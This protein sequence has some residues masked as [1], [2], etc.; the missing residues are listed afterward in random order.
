MASIKDVKA[1]AQQFLSKGNYQKALKYYQAI[2]D[3]LEE[4]NTPDITLYNKVGDI[5]LSKMDN[6]DIA[7]ENFRKAMYL[8]GKDSLYPN[9]IA[10]AKKILKTDSNQIEMYRKIG[11][12]NREQGLVGE[13][14]NNFIN[15][16]EK[17]LQN[18]DRKAAIEAFKDTLDMMPE[19]IEIKEKLVDLYVQEEELEKAIELLK[20]VEG[21]YV[22]RNDMEQA[23]LIRQKITKYSKQAGIVT[24]PVE[25]EKPQPKPAQAA[26]SSEEEIDIEDFDMSDLVD[27]LTQ[28]LDESFSEESEKTSAPPASAPEPEGAEALEEETESTGS[29]ESEIYLQ[30]VQMGELSENY[31]ANEAANFYYQAAEGYTSIE[32]Y[33]NAIGAYRKIVNLKENEMKAHKAIIDLSIKTSQPSKAVDSYLY[34]AK[35]S[36]DKEPE[37]TMKLIDTVLAADPANQEAI[38]MKSRLTQAQ[39]PPQQPEPAKHEQKPAQAEPMETDFLSEFKEE[40]TEDLSGDDLMKESEDMTARDIVNGKNEGKRPKFSIEQ[41]SQQQSDEVWSL[42]ELLDELKEGVNE[43]LSDED[44]SSHYDLG[45]S[46]KEMGLHD[47]A[48]EELK[49]SLANPEY[50]LKSLEMLGQC[51]FEKNDLETAEHTL[52]EAMSI[53]GKKPEEYLGIKYTLARIYE[54]RQMLEQALKM[55]TQIKQTDASFKNIDKHIALIKEAM[56]KKIQKEQV[57]KEKTGAAAETPDDGMVDF[58]ALLKDEDIAQEEESEFD[59]I[60]IDL[61]DDDDNNKSKNISYM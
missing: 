11:E 52:I 5:Y 2:I 24:K 4:K 3:K 48:I 1:K 30:Y 19:R 12:F 29:E 37:K 60:E 17:S 61:D 20:E 13:A 16:A 15:F 34:L 38:A 54:S 50:K 32:E 18:G 40:I 28:E 44:V 35:Q 21:H 6:K 31:D 7:I 14:L 43:N 59:D 47:M 26:P 51:Y 9:A 41:D 10:M 25:K 56:E 49:K 53:K 27:N 42:N 46:F 39:V 58:S 55:M 22:K 33:D 36:I 57:P 23:A 8:Y 45:V